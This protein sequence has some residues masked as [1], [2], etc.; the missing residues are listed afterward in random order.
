LIEPQNEDYRRAA[1]L[2]RQYEDTRLDYVDSLI[3]AIA[4]RLGV[5]TVLTLDRR[6]FHMVRPRHCDAFQILP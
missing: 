3:V 6:H 5:T 4:E 2:V 1:Q